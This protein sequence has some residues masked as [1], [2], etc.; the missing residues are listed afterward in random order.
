MII[1][2]VSPPPLLSPAPTAEIPNTNTP[3]ACSFPESSNC[4]PSTFSI[5]GP[6]TTNINIYNLNTV[7]ASIVVFRDG[8]DI[9]S[10]VDNKGVFP[11]WDRCASGGLWVVRE[12]GRGEGGQGGGGGVKALCGLRMRCATGA[13]PSVLVDAG[14]ASGF[15]HEHRSILVIR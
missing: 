5:E 1:I 8:Q 14:K 7:G 10:A 6:E 4:Q 11:G 12:A 3:Q 2:T 13:W 9:A 15:M